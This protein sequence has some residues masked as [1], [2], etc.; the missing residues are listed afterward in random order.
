[1]RALGAS[2]RQLSVAQ[3]I[4]IAASGALA[5]LLAAIGALVVGSVLAE[6]VF[7]F[8]LSLRLSLLPLGALGG[9]LLSLLAGWL[10]LRHV[11]DSPP[12]TVLRD[13]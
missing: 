2:R 8:E 1:M 6:R 12:M 7:D 5:G 9:A 4:E 10:G 11:L 13:A 3:L